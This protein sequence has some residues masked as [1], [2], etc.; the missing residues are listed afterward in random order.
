M[1]LP[2][3]IFVLH[4]CYKSLHLHFQHPGGSFLFGP[5]TNPLNLD[6]ISC[7]R[8]QTCIESF[9]QFSFVWSWLKLNKWRRRRFFWLVKK[10]NEDQICVLTIWL[11]TI[12]KYFCVVL[13]QF[14]KLKGYLK[15]YIE[16]LVSSMIRKNWRESILS[17]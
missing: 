7:N 5:I 10:R 13:F 14:G 1:G 11:R 8:N 6:H 9:S 16:N 4:N 2:S 15:G 12:T 3:W 17:T